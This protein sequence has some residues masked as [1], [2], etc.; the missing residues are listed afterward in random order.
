MNSLNGRDSWVHT[1][2]SEMAYSQNTLGY[3]EP[4]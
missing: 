1:F 3:H 4:D 2:V